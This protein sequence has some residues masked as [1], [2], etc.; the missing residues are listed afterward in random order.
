M[1]KNEPVTVEN[2]SY[3][4]AKN[5][6]IAYV[7]MPE[8]GTYTLGNVEQAICGKLTLPKGS[9]KPNKEQEPGSTKGTLILD[10]KSEY[11]ISWTELETKSPYSNRIT[12]TATLTG[13]EIADRNNQYGQPALD[14]AQ[15]AR[16]EEQGKYL[17]KLND[18]Y[19]PKLP[20][21]NKELIEEENYIHEKTKESN[22][23]ELSE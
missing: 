19:Q 18:V 5:G 21:F 3:F 12:K 10:A 20:F 13:Q 8:I 16:R 11:T 7:P 17:N 4:E 2:V 23:P 1:S 6:T 22:E 14:A 15:R 9:I